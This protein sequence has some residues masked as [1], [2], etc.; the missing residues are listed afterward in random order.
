MLAGATAMVVAAHAWTTSRRVRTWIPVAGTL[1]AS[2][3][4]LEARQWRRDGSRVFGVRRSVVYEYTYAGRA[5][6]GR[7][8]ARWLRP[9]RPEQPWRSRSEAPREW[10]FP[11]EVYVD[12]AD[13]SHSCLDPNVPGHRA[14]AYLA[15]GVIALA[16]AA[17]IAR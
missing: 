10:D 9:W 16:F 14:R 3:L 12:P 7:S 6:S 1:A 15:V 13:P 17:L 8:E 5:Y 11:I 4:T 2:G